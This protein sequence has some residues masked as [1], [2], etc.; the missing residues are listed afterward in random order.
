MNTLETAVVLLVLLL[1]PGLAVLL[2]F[3]R[4]RPAALALAPWAA[5]PA[6]LV[7]LAGWPGAIVEIE[8]LL[9]GAAFGLDE[10][11]RGFLL[12]T[13]ALW[14]A[15]GVAA[16]AYH[17][18]DPRRTRLFGFHLVTL[19]GNLGLVLAQDAVSFYLF[20][21]VMS[22][23]ASGLIVHVA[24]PEARRASRVYLVLV[25]LGEALLLPGLWMAVAGA[26]SF[27]LADVAANVAERGGITMLLLAAGFGVKAGVLPLHVWLP[28]AHPVAPTPSSAL[29]SGAMIKA[30]VLGWITFLPLGLGS[31]P[32][33][34]A[35]FILGG[36]SAAFYGAAVGVVQSKAKTV[37]AYS[38]I[39]QMGYMTAAVGIGL[40]HADAW[41]L[42]AAAVAVY[43]LHHALAKGALFLGVG[44]VENARG[45]RARGFALALL[46]VPA[47][48]LAG[49]P[50]TS[51]LIA[52]TM[53]KEAATQLQALG[54]A[55]LDLLLGLAAFATTVLMARFLYVLARKE[56]GARRE[57]RAKRRRRGLW[58]P[59]LGL[60]AASAALGVMP[61]VVP[62]LMSF[63]IGVPAETAAVGISA[64]WSAMWPLGLGIAAAAGV[65]LLQR[66]GVT[67]LDPRRASP[68]IPEGDILWPLVGIGRAVAQTLPRPPFPIIAQLGSAAAG[69]RR[70]SR[71][72]AARLLARAE[73][74]LVSWPGVGSGVLIAVLVIFLL[75]AGT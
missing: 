2:M 40:M 24:S 54:N 36:V 52:K 57:V 5:L 12:L 15:G 63:L 61:G 39:S 64:W 66:R 28:L 46:L 34:A 29:L 51:G 68:P 25:V 17:R 10:A 14:L 56:G 35:V 26:T 16:G 58:P 62:G 1:P 71:V 31:Y 18:A 6:F 27:G 44:V 42:A 43:A 41:P 59:W 23:A 48:A 4:A 19:F 55:P 22:F 7:A 13:A 33:L 49:A 67:L 21:L 53:L 3:R 73:Q 32:G 75:L 9:L 50:L 20:F 11:R 38:S 8:W 47:L 74:S 72:V 45:E 30:G 69:R 65:L 37:L 70:R 60:I